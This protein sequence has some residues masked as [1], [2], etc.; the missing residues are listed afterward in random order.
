MFRSLQV[1]RTSESVRTGTEPRKS[2]P[3]GTRVRVVNFKDGVLTVRTEDKRF[4]NAVRL[5][6]KTSQVEQTFRGRPRKE[7]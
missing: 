3:K 5:S 7:V 4:E 6:L 2:F 1:L